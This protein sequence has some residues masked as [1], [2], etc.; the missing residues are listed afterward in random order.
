[1]IRC[2]CHCLE[3]NYNCI[4]SIA[5]LQVCIVADEFDVFAQSRQYDATQHNPA[6]SYSYQS[7][8]GGQGAASMASAASGSY[9]SQVSAHYISIVM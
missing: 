8:A 6:A 3:Q 5:I 9:A 7:E 2:A 1:M 4:N